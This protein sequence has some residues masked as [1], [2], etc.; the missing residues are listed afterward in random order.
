MKVKKEEFCSIH[1][2]ALEYFCRDDEQDICQV[3]IIFGEHKE[4]RYILKKEF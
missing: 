2:K 3:C 1:E 4:H